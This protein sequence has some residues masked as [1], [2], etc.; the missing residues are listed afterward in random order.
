MLHI[1]KLLEMSYIELCQNFVATPQV[2]NMTNY[3][4]IPEKNSRTG[5]SAFITV[6]CSGSPIPNISLE[7]CKLNKTEW[8]SFPKLIPSIGTRIS[9]SQTV[10]DSIGIQHKAF[11]VQI[12]YFWHFPDYK[13]RFVCRNEHGNSTSNETQFISMNI[14]F[15]FTLFEIHTINIKI[16]N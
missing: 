7:I 11:H 4:I 10:V 6:D 12:D 15:V 9:T 1:L 5:Y 16:P 3:S 14:Y 13:L 8:K 2:T